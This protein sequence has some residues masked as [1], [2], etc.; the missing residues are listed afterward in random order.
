MESSK[1]FL[2][3][4]LCNCWTNFEKLHKNV[5]LTLFKNYSS[6]FDPSRNVLWWWGW[7]LAQ[8]EYEGILKNSFSLN[9][10]VRF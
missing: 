1:E 2:K 6:H 5:S 7:L 10:P 3:Y 4:L 9:P 8:F